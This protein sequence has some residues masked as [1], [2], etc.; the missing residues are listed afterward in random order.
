[1]RTAKVIPNQK[2]LLTRLEFGLSEV[3]GVLEVTREALDKA[4]SEAVYSA[5]ELAIKRIDEL[6]ELVDE[7]RRVSNG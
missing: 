5:L 6:N 3:W 1:M 4:P 7:V 2:E